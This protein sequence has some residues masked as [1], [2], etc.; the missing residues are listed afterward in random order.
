MIG[1]NAYAS[2]IAGGHANCIADTASRSTI[3]GGHDNMIGTNAYQSTIAGGLE[4]TIANEA[5]TSTISGGTDNTVQYGARWSSI[6]GGSGNTVRSNATYATIP[7]GA[8]GGAR[9]Y[10]QWAYASGSFNETPDSGGEA[11][12]SLYVL[13][14][15]TTTNEPIKKLFLDGYDAQMIV[16]NGSTWV[17]EGMVVGRTKD[18]DE[19]PPTATSAGYEIRGVVVNTGGYVRLI[20]PTVDSFVEE[21]ALWDVDLEADN[22]NKAL[23]IR[24]TGDQYESVCWV[25][26]VRTTEVTFPE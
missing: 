5:H 13:R 18:T 16:P 7:G 1:T 14:Q 15:M 12:T 23:A 19:Q 17:F 26:T 21:N 8:F 4:N 11:Q 24:V 20:N 9:S 10:G 3:G 22:T 25:A 6:G 2:T